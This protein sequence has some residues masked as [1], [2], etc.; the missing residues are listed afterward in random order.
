MYCKHCGQEITGSDH[1]CK[2]GDNSVREKF[3]T[4]FLTDDEVHLG[5]L[6]QGLLPN[7][8]F[9][10]SLG[11]QALI[12][13]DKRIYS[14]AKQ[15]TKG[16]FL[17]GHTVQQLETVSTYGFS[18][19]SYPIFIVVIIISLATTIL[20]A[21]FEGGSLLG[22]GIFGVLVGLIGYFFSFQ[23]YFYIESYST[24]VYFNINYFEKDQIT[25]FIRELAKAIDKTNGMKGR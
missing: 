14:S 6:F 10:G 19:E 13:S 20:G 3:K 2:P 17:H 25:T 7:L 5:H 21:F 1:T 22:I 24:R 12:L 23:T 16:R 15:L 11:K 4:L 9:W 8:V 18:K